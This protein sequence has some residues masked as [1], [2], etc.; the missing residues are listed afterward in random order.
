[1]GYQPLETDPCLFVLLYVD[2]MLIACYDE[3]EYTRI[4]AIL[5][6]NFKITSLRDVSNYLGIRV[7]RAGP[8]FVHPHDSCKVC[9]SR[10]KTIPHPNGPRIYETTATIAQEGYLPELLRC[11][12]VCGGKHSARYCVD[13]GEQGQPSNPS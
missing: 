1:M 12:A 10:R 13:P 8:I 7:Q 11:F 3:T 9:T 4:E 6:K 2:D 5:R